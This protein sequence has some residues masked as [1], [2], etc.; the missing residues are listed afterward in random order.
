VALL[1]RVLTFH[2]VTVLDEAH[3]FWERR[4]EGSL[5]VGE[6]AAVCV[7]AGAPF[8]ANASI[9]HPRAG[10]LT[11]AQRDEMVGDGW[12][13]SPRSSEDQKRAGG[14]VPARIVAHTSPVCASFGADRSWCP[15][16]DAPGR[17]GLSAPVCDPCV[18]FVTR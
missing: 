3:G 8:L 11:A 14:V 6:A 13:T 18:F 5:D 1:S 7:A 9:D 16:H 10:M 12:F 15:V 17:G 2:N 4:S